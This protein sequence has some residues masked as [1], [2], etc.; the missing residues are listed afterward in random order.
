MVLGGDSQVF[1]SGIFM[2]IHRRYSVILLMQMISILLYILSRL[3]LYRYIPI[4]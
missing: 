4:V 2:E 1:H 3:N